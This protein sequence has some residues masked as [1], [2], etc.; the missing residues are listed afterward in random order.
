MASSNEASRTPE[1]NWRIERA[2]NLLHKENQTRAKIFEKLQER[3]LDRDKLSEN[4]RRLLPFLYSYESRQRKFEYIEQTFLGVYSTCEAKPNEPLS[5]KTLCCKTRHG[6]NSLA[7]EKKIFREITA[8]MDTR[9]DVESAKET[10]LVH[11]KVLFNQTHP[12]K[13]I[14]NANVERLKQKMQV[15]TKDIRSIEKRLHRINQKKDQIYA[16]ILTLQKAA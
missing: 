8:A 13:M 16:Q 9:E 15:I 2:L 5:I 11:N 3:K 12:I 6:S 1:I 14:S 7:D 10:K 4:I